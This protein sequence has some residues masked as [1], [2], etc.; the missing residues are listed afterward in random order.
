MP[1]PVKISQHHLTLVM[2]YDQL[3]HPL[4]NFN[5]LLPLEQGGNPPMP[6]SQPKV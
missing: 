4:Y 1:T 6:N 5:L 2:D 3:S